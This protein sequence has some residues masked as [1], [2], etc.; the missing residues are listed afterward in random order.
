MKFHSIKVSNSVIGKCAEWPQWLIGSRSDVR[1]PFRKLAQLLSSTVASYR[2]TQCCLYL[3]TSLV[4]SESVNIVFVHNSFVHFTY[5]AYLYLYIYKL[6]VNTE[7]LQTLS[8]NK[9]LT[10]T[11][12]YILYIFWNIFLDLNALDTLNPLCCCNTEISPH[13]SSRGWE[14]LIGF[15]FL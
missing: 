6:S 13:C 14:A 15:Y 2:Y 12:L 3:Q 4:F 9:E 5:C 11:F 10:D 1:I 7:L 8:V